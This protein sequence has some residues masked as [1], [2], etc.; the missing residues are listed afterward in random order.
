MD[1]REPVVMA[2]AMLIDMGLISRE[3]VETELE[4][5]DRRFL[6]QEIP[7]SLRDILYKLEEQ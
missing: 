7:R 4:K 1:S 6:G 3:R 5:V 2:M